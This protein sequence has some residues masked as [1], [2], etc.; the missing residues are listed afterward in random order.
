MLN[1]GRLRF[2]PTLAWT[3]GVWLLAAAVFFRNFL[4]TG[5]D[6]IIGDAGDARLD[7][8][9]RENLHQFLRGRAEFL[10]P[11]M[12]FPIKGTLGYSD[13]YL[14]DGLI[15]VPLRLIGLDPFL[16]F[17][18]LCIGISLVGFIS[19]NILLMRFANVRQPVAALAAAIFVFSNSLY[20]KMGHPQLYEVNF[21][22]LVAV[23]FLEAA[24]SRTIRPIG[25]A[26]M[27]LTGGVILGLLFSTGYYVAWYFMFLSGL[28]LV[29]AAVLRFSLWPPSALSARLYLSLLRRYSR[30]GTAGALGFVVGA[31]PFWKIYAPVIT[32]VSGRQF[33]EYLENAPT[34]R[35]LL[36][37][38]GDNLLWGRAIDVLNIVPRDHLFSGE[39]VLAITPV[40][41]ITFL[42][43]VWAVWRDRLLSKPEDRFLRITVL[44]CFFAVAF[45]T[46]LMVKVGQFSL[47]WLAWHLV[48]GANALRAGGRVQLVMNGFVVAVVAIV[49][50]QLLQTTVSWRLRLVAWV[51]LLVCVLEQINVVSNHNLSRAEEMAAL[52]IVPSPLA[53]CRAFYILPHTL[54]RGAT[55][56]QVNAMLIAQVENLPTLNGYSGWAP[57]GW[58]LYETALPTYRSNAWLWAASHG[59]GDGLCEYDLARREW[60]QVRED[61]ELLAVGAVL[62]PGSS[63]DLRSGGGGEIYDFGGWSRPEGPG[64]WTDGPAAALAARLI[65]WPAA[66]MILRVTARPFLVREQHPLLQ[67]NVEV[68]GSVVDRWT[69]R[70]DQDNDFVTRSARVAKSLLADA[71]VLKVSFRIDHPASPKALGVHPTDDRSLGLFV[72]RVSFDAAS[73]HGETER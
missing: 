14:L 18:L 16:S 65:Q 49:F 73:S 56:Q 70:Y 51:L 43:S 2:V 46:V 53:D 29:F 41:L 9:L 24:R 5:F 6:K 39:F 72:S 55:I 21:I 4:L 3:I 63:I 59:I 62:N 13:A 32:Q 38:S 69:Y 64:T 19:A 12:F 33:A 27:A 25:S 11:P 15:Y 50:T 60:R 7:I 42:F 22:P 1:Q 28:V 61:S 20:I 30:V 34:V 45:M 68:N 10:S 40:L 35:E 57:A 17:E 48:P 31:I 67:V 26:M 44:A 66:D 52:R 36:N 23:L 8:F 71:P 54:E 47:F 37:V 58:S